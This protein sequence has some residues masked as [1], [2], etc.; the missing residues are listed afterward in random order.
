MNPKLLIRFNSVPYVPY[1]CS[2]LQFLFNTIE[3]FYNSKNRLPQSLNNGQTHRSHMAA[4]HPRRLHNPTR[5]RHSIYI[6][7]GCR[8]PGRR[9]HDSRRKS[10]TTDHQP[11]KLLRPS[12]HPSAP[13][14]PYS[15]N[16][17][18]PL[19]QPRN[20][21]G[22]RHSCRGHPRLHGLQWRRRPIRK[23]LVHRREIGNRPDIG[24]CHWRWGTP[25]DVAGE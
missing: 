12:P 4:H 23:L 17:Q 15:H 22:S 25:V 5:S 21:L 19:P 8:N 6:R 16:R 1:Y 2:K 20:A 18:P 9:N 3:K 7:T 11:P 13:P 10:R 24:E 14:Q